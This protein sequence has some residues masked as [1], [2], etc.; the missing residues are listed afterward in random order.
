M[1]TGDLGRIDK[2]GYLWL[3]GRAK[4]L[5]EGHN[6]D[7]SVI[8]DAIAGHQDIVAVGTLLGNLTRKLEKYRVRMHNL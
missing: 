2:D 3:T 4:D 5:I 8:E 6:I 1:R 7:P